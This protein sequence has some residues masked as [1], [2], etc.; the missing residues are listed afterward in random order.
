LTCA[1]DPLSSAHA[2]AVSLMTARRAT[3]P[4]GDT[5]QKVSKLLLAVV[6][7]VVGASTAQAQRFGAH[8][9]WANDFELGVGARLEMDM[10]GKL[11]KQPPLSRAF[12]IGQFDYY[13]DPCEGGDCTVFEINPG[14]AVPLNATTLKPYVGAGLNIARVSVDL[15]PTF[16]SASDTEIGLNL[17]GGLK[18]NLS[19]MDAFTEAR[20]ALGGG[21]QF[22]IAFGILFG[23]TKS[24]S[25]SPKR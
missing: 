7:V 25:Q 4:F 6:L 5:M 24:A 10:A 17:L 21:E 9:I 13:L 1:A 11:S 3:L 22:S 19:G 16:G 12:F 8:A 14:I 15:G 2:H 23:G 20:L 18:L